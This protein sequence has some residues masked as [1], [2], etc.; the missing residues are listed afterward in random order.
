M[1]VIKIPIKYHPTFPVSA[2][3]ITTMY[4]F[5]ADRQARIPTQSALQIVV[6]LAMATEINGAWLHMNIHQVVHDPALDVVLDAVD[7]EPAAHINHLDE[8][9]VSE[10]QRVFCM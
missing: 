4:L 7:Q 5:A 8:G 2:V 10:E 3:L 6:A 9:Q 1:Q